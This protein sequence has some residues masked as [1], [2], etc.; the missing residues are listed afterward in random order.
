MSIILRSNFIFNRN[1]V[2]LILRHHI[3]VNIKLQ[4]VLPYQHALGL[5]CP[6]FITQ[7]RLSCSLVHSQL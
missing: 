3:T 4:E 6:Y 5:E 7:R 2:H 1:L